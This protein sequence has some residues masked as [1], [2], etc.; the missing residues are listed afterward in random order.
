MSD[1]IHLLPDSVANQIAAGEVIQRPA[2]VI[3]EL[4]ENALD[5]GAKTVD[6]SVVEAGRASIQVIDD[7]KGMSETDARLSFERHATSKIRLADDLFNLR[8][9]GFRGEALAS[10]AAVAQVQL[11]TRTRNE[12]IGTQL[13]IAGSRFKDQEP[14]ACPV[15]SNFLI[16]NLFYNVPARRKFLKSNNT[17]LNHIITAF[18]RIA[19]VYPDV[20]FSLRSNN[21]EMF[22]L[23]AGGL[24]QRI[25][26]I[27]GKRINQD[28]LPVNVETSMCGLNGFV[29]KPESARKKGAH[30]YFFVNGRYMR[31]PYFHK[32]VTTAFD[33]LVPQG[34]QVPYFLYFDV[35]PKDIDV[36][37]HPTKTEIKFENE[38]AIWQI[39]LA[40]VKDAVGRFNN[41]S[42]IDFDTEGKPDIPVFDPNNHA[43]A[44]K[45]EY[46]PTYNPFDSTQ[47]SCSHSPKASK[48]SKGD[49]DQIIRSHIP[50]QWEQLY[51]DIDAGSERQHDTLFPETA[52]GTADSLIAEKS[53]AHYQYKGQYI[54]TAVKSGLMV[55]DQHRAHIRILFDHF[56]RQLATQAAHA[57]K[58]LF[59]DTIQLSVQED[60]LYQ[61]IAEEVSA[62][63]FELANLG[64]GTYAI[65]AMP[66][67]LEGVD[68][69]CLLHDMLQSVQDRGVAANQ[70]VNDA[71]ALS[72][73][74][75]AAIPYGQALSNDEMEN[76]VNNLF[77]CSNV[78]YTPDG[79]RVL[80]I[81]KQNDI[82]QM[83]R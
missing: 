57:Q 56:Q 43:E 36:N 64:G 25:V 30:Q 44:P 54:M 45:V 32:A 23:R 12:E 76:I 26:D 82:E 14:C 15:G 46:N 79:K 6:V 49:A 17:E 16:E 21:S 31:H 19:L 8:T 42:T 51:D 28:L 69:L 7:G 29:G 58:I 63:G 71:I 74:R 18:Q 27:F 9:M 67:G 39:V 35:D 10:I 60:T 81:L 38:Q 80:Y 70:E 2:S 34:D 3:K 24:R 66:E 73:A 59:P 55:V 5:A 22:N 20:A 47:A 50:S 1:V 83:L 75:A 13:S 77:V 68:V 52:S 53:P 40:A 33:R 62:M 11:K 41:V 37:I 78:N 48:P 4:M 72:M 61:T 65:N